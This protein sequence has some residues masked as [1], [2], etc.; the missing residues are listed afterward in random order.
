MRIPHTF[1]K[2]DNTEISA[3]QVG[4]DIAPQWIIDMNNDRTV[5]FLGNFERMAVKV[6]DEIA[7][8]GDYILNVDGKLSVMN[9]VEFQKVYSPKT[10]PADVVIE[11]SDDEN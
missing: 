11:K 3:F 7:H 9:A 6:G 1:L 4:L 10:I 5:E 8:H 2:S